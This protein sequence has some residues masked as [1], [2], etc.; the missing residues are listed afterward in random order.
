[1]TEHPARAAFATLAQGLRQ[2]YRVRW[3]RAA[4]WVLAFAIVLRVALGLLLHRAVDLLIAPQ[5]L[6][7]RWD[8]LDLSILSGRG[9]LRDFEIAPREDGSKAI[10]VVDYAVFDLNLL[11][12]LAGKL[13]IRRL[14]V[15]GMQLRLEREADGSWKLGK[16][17]AE[18]SPTPPEEVAKTA[19]KDEKPAPFDLSPPLSV[20]ALRVQDVSI[21]FEDRTFTPPA[22]CDLHLDVEVSYLGIAGRPTRFSTTLTGVHVLD[23]ARIEGEGE[24][25]AD[26]V[27]LD[28]RTQIGGLR[29]RELRP[30]L[31]PAGVGPACDSIQASFASRVEADVTGKARDSV[32]IAANVSD[33][34]VAADGVES[35]AL[36]RLDLG[37][38][39]LS[40]HAAE[41]SRIELAGARANASLEPGDVLRVAGLDLSSTPTQEGGTSWQDSLRDL[42]RTLLGDRVPPWAELLVR[43][44]P[45]AFAWS[46][47][48]F[49][50]EKS[51]VS[52]TDHRVD[53]PASFPVH[54]DAI[55]LRDVRHHRGEELAPIPVDVRVRIPGTVENVRLAGRIAPFVPRRS[56]D[57]ELALEDVSLDAMEGYL[58]AAGLERQPA[59]TGLRFRLTGSASTD[60]GGV[61]EGQLAL[62]ESLSVEGRASSSLGNLRATELR[63]DPGSRLLRLGNVEVSGS[64]LVVGRDPSRRLVAFGMRT[65]GFDAERAAAAPG[66]ARAPKAVPSARP[67]SSAGPLPRVEIGRFAWTDG[68][69]TFVD[70]SVDPPRSLAIGPMGLEL[71]GL[72]VGGSAGD[73]EPAPAHLLARAVAPGMFDE[74]RLEGNVR[75]HL[76]GIDLAA[77]LALSGKGFRGAEIA[78]YLREIGIE[79]TLE[80]GE[81][82]LGIHAEIR[83]QDGWR[84]SLRLSDGALSDGGRPI[85]GLRELRLDDFVAADG[86]ISIGDLAIVGPYARIERARGSGV[87]AAGMR[88]A[89]A[90]EPDAAPAPTPAEPRPA[91]KVAQPLTLPSLPRVLLEKGSLEGARVELRDASTEPPIECAILVSGT[92]KDLG[93]SGVPGR[94]EARVEIPDAVESIDV[95]SDVRAGP[96]GIHVGTSLSAKGVHGGALALFLPPGTSFEGKGGTLGVRLDA[97]VAPAKGGG[98]SARVSASDLSW[99]DAGSEPWL[100]CRKI[101]VEVPRVDPVAGLLSVGPVAIE[102]LTLEGERGADGSTS[103]LGFRAVAAPSRADPAPAA[104][105]TSAASAASAAQPPAKTSEPSVFSRVELAGNV[106]LALERFRLRDA[107]APDARPLEASVAFRVDGPRLLLGGPPEQLPPIPWSV[108]GGVPGLVEHGRVEGELAPFA[109]EPGFRA[110]LSAEN[111][112]TQGLVEIAPAL[113]AKLHGDVERG[114]LEARLDG[115]LSVHRSGPTDLGLRRPFGADV[116]LENLAF[117][118]EPGGEILAGVDSIV[119]DADRID[120][121]KGVVH[122][123]TVEITQ[124]RGLVRRTPTAISVCGLAFELAPAPA[125]GDAGAQTPP[126]APAPAP[127]AAVD[128]SSPP[129]KPHPGA[130]SGEFRVEH[131]IVGG[132]ACEL[133]DERTEPPRVLPLAALDVEARGL[134]TRALRERSPLRFHLLLSGG[135][136]TP[137]AAAT[138]GDAGTKA[139]DPWFDE[140]AL[141]GDLVLRPEISGNLRLSLNGLDLR[142]ILDRL[143]PPKGLSVAKGDLDLRTELRFQGASDMH[144]QTSLVFSELVVEESDGGPVQTHLKLPVTLNTA[145]FLLRNPAGEH[146]ISAGFSFDPHNLGSG[147]LAIAATEAIAGVLAVALAGAPLRLVGAFVP[148]E[149]KAPAPPVEIAFAPGSSEL[150][151]D[152]EAKLF[153]LRKMLAANPSLQ[154]VVRHELGAED[155]VRAERLA[156][157][158]E[159]TCRDLVVRSRQRKSE[160]QRDRA[161]AATRVRALL[162]VG[163]REAAAERE[164]LCAMDR[165]LASVEDDLDRV[166]EILRSPSPRRAQKRTRAAALEIGRDR[167][168]A[169]VKRCSLGLDKEDAKRIEPSS[170]RYEAREDGGTGRV[171]LELRAR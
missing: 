65:L 112:R 155:L 123:R 20:E 58:R 78:P 7:C 152:V 47:G 73:A 22:T 85:L 142:E 60:A 13:R 92:A 93:T 108:E 81:G 159:A 109:V 131:L 138:T 150:P 4:V 127:V 122:V 15:D 84:G 103:F 48:R 98:V 119:A 23:G 69:F 36:D 41:L 171:L 95:A 129:S 153:T 31:G 43:D 148:Q 33:L 62:D 38:D 66:P 82:A 40:R 5:G 18:S 30:W 42:F 49:A 101:D 72:T 44:D 71:T 113:A 9:E 116:R 161:E 133:R 91:K 136:P 115:K 67:P 53:P 77:D 88:F 52:L 105:A 8:D 35:V 168:D 167:I 134:T 158:P 114:T 28:L 32:R 12:L 106:A 163:A 27:A 156:N 164:S 94:V 11:P 99:G 68:H 2:L 118:R 29:P 154:L 17:S 169:V 59:K 6:A 120:L 25:T 126:E 170:P 24:W 110:S 75:T 70:A 100:A 140:L 145:L 34:V 79:P 37:V 14:E 102:G 121:A 89:K 151:A 64:Q 19:S 57:L 86:T 125:D 45:R 144:V 147:R 146:R 90:S 165:E 111:V 166:L 97:E 50:I 76:G 83:N 21:A 104:P 63:I 117:R 16:E 135:P 130:A 143:G 141:S 1:M 132:V 39:A 87:D 137:A 54:V 74:I 80:N 139:S 26:R 46:L 160:L 107:S 55:E 128:P 51:E 157:P 61:T 3:F 56:V 10:A 96:D 162:A 124:P 149:K